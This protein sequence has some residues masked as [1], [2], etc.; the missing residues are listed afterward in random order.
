MRNISNI[1][2]RKT[3]KI[4]LLRYERNWSGQYFP[5]EL[6]KIFGKKWR[7]K[8]K[9]IIPQG[10]W[11]EKP[12]GI[13]VCFAYK[14]L[15]KPH[16]NHKNFTFPCILVF[17]VIFPYFSPFPSLLFRDVTA[18]LGAVTSPKILG[19]ENPSFSRCHGKIFDF[20]VTSPKILGPETY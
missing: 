18:P 15:G 17:F 20:A 14:K 12:C 10:F 16:K 5:F 4:A 13:T 1:K 6:R 2:T 9:T 11:E 7:A 3:T 8:K 19:P